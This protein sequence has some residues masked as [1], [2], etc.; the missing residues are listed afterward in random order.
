MALEPRELAVERLALEQRRGVLGLARRRPG[1][2]CARRL[3]AVEPVELGEDAPG[4][5]QLAAE[6]E[7][8]VGV[9]LAIAHV[10][11]VHQAPI[12]SRR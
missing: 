2:G 12:V 10:D 7:R 11:H 3:L 1:V 9:E 5:V 8:L 4:P 6:Q